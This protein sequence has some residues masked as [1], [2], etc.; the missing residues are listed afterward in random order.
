MVWLKRNLFLVIFGVIALGLLGYATMYFLGN[1]GKNKELDTQ[2]EETR[3]QINQLQRKSP[4]PSE[5]N[6]ALAQA[7]LGRIRQLINT[8]QGFY[9]PIPFEKVADRDFR[10]LLDNTIF[11]LQSKARQMGIELPERDYAFSFKAQKTLYTFAPGSFPALP[12]QLAEIK[13]LA[14]VIFAAKINRLENIKR[15]RV[16]VDD[17]A[18]SADY[19][20]QI[21]TTND[22]T[23]TISNPYQVTFHSFS[24][25][26]AA[27]LEGFYKS[28]HGIIVKTVTVEPAPEATAA[29]AGGQQGQVATGGQVPTRPPGTSATPTTQPPPGTVAPGVQPAVRPAAPPAGGTRRPGAPEVLK[30]VLNE[31][32]LKITMA[33]EV[34][35]PI[36]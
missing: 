9:A 27:A 20:D 3:N 12:E 8:A 36:Q 30:T 28:Q 13:T 23:K 6:I 14:G 19:H 17:P 22:L 34:I 10:A 32:L 2:L 18:G 1:R 25:E 7:E 29:Q 16:T 5:T 26:L 24:A 31:K 11:E 15:M 21:T 33:I 4:F 35:K